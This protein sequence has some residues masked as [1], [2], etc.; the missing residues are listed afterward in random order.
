MKIKAFIRA[1]FKIYNSLL[2]EWRSTV[3]IKWHCTERFLVRH[4]DREVYNTKFKKEHAGA[5]GYSNYDRAIEFKKETST[6]LGMIKV[7][8]TNY[9]KNKKQAFLYA[10]QIW[11]DYG[12][13]QI[14]SYV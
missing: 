4:P 12:K 8:I 6:N 9:L 1:Y 13:C 2:W 5:S 14:E 11:R 7:T 3:V 10:R